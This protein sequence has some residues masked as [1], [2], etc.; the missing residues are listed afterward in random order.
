MAI[1]RQRPIEGLAS[2]LDLALQGAGSASMPKSAVSQ[3]RAPLGD[4][5]LKW[6]FERCSQ[7]WAHERARRH[8]CTLLT[9]LIDAKKF[10][11]DELRAL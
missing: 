8:D 7:K 4:E 10:P 9:S 1:Y 11:A 2:H 3:T 6:L 5:P